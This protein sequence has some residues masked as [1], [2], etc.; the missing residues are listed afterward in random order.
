MSCAEGTQDGKKDILIVLDAHPPLAGI[1]PPS[2]QPCVA[3]QL[4]HSEEVTCS[5][6]CNL[7]AD[8]FAVFSKVLVF[9]KIK[10]KGVTR[11]L[12]MA[13]RMAKAPLFPQTV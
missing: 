9:L 3:H 6:F 4:Q 12:E 7:A 8:G 5:E 13:Q 1:Y 11:C 2:G 10:V